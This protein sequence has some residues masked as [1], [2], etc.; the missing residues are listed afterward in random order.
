M[1]NI[2]ELYNIKSTIIE[3]TK[4]PSLREGHRV[5]VYLLLN[6]SLIPSISNVRE[7]RRVWSSGLLFAVAMT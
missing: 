5:G 3:S 4:N 6:K 2:F 7:K 1:P